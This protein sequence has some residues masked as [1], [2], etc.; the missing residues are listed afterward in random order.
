MRGALHEP[1]PAGEL[2]PSAW[3]LLGEVP[4]EKKGP[5]KGAYL[6]TRSQRSPFDGWA[7]DLTQ[8]GQYK[9]Y[10]YPNLQ[11]ARMIWYHDHA[12]GHVSLGAKPTPS[13][14]QSCAH[15]HR[16]LMPYP[17]TQTAENAYFGQA[18][19]YIIHD[20][21]ED[22][23]GLPSGYGKYDIPLIL[24]SKVREDSPLHPSLT[25]SIFADDGGKEEGMGWLTRGQKHSNTTATAASSRRQ[26]R[27]TA[28]MATSSTS[29]GN[30]GRTSRSS[31][32]GTGCGSSTRPSRARS[33]ST[34]RS[35]A[36]T[37][38]GKSW[39]LT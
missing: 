11:S 36:V 24:A 33:C 37:R 15:V 25:N 10:F 39:T 27:T 4:P 6:L 9:D 22:A 1:R 23:L 21:D 20:A 16:Q 2:G 28:C 14:H 13:P 29:T 8:P 30:R 38:R 3:K 7:E 18:G 26:T 19:A 32:G 17:T 34:L 5:K 31:R 35:T 12:I